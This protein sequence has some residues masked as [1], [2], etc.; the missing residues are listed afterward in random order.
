MHGIWQEQDPIASHQWFLK[1]AEQGSPGAMFGLASQFEQGEGVAKDLKQAFSYYQAAAEKGHP[2]AQHKIG[3]FYYLGKGAAK[4]AVLAFT[5]LHLA[6]ENLAEGAAEA[7]DMVGKT[8]NQQEVMLAW[9]KL[10]SIRQ[11]I[12]AMGSLDRGGDTSLS[13]GS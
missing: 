13:P 6:A 5:W 2:K 11:R 12:D 1:A 3:F 10:Q 8:L 7:R 4:D 9:E